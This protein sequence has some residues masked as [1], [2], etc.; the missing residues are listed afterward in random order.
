MIRPLRQWHRR[1]IL[2]LGVILPIG[3]ALGLAGRKSVPVDLDLP[4]ALA[5]APAST[6]TLFWANDHLFARSPV[7]VRLWRPPAGS[8]S[9]A[10]SFSAAPD[11]LK[12]DLMVYWVTYGATG[13]DTFPTNAVMLG[14]FGAAPL[15]LPNEAFRAMGE[16]VLYSLADY[17][18]V[19]AS[20][21][22]MLD[23]SNPP[24]EP[25]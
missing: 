17:E 15:R 4:A 24:L 25:P 8:R 2:T 3:L 18:I 9:W 20:K 13:D 5:P 14:T 11:F 10:V 22:F 23:N 16:L 1:Q 7:T 19:D 12:P 6:G 21:P